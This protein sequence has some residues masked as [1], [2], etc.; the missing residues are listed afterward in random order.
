ML[1]RLAGE[2]A[3]YLAL[4]AARQSTVVCPSRR[5]A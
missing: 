4:Q 3:G 1:T 2:K 5:A